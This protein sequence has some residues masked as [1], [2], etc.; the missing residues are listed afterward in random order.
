MLVEFHSTL[1]GLLSSF[2]T[3]VNSFRRFFDQFLQLIIFLQI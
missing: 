3:T 1:N 2:L